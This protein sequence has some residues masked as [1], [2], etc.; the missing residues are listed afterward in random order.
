MNEIREVKKSDKKEVTVE[1]VQA[2]VND[3]AAKIRR[4]SSNW[5]RFAAVHLGS[6]EHV[7]GKLNGGFVPICILTAIAALS[8]IAG[9]VFAANWDISAPGTGTCKAED[10]AGTFTMT[11][12]V[13]NPTTLTISAGAL[14][15][16][17]VV[18]ADLAVAVQRLGVGSVA[19]VATPNA[20]G[21]TN[22]VV[23]TL[24][25]L[26]GNTLAVA[27]QASAFTF[28]I[29]DSAFGVPA[30]VAGNIV[31]SGGYEIKE[32]TDKAVYTVLTATN[33]TVTVTVTDT[34]GGTN[35]FHCVTG[36]GIVATPTT[37][38][39]NVP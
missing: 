37:M 27:G 32:L 29:S 15:D 9:S 24:A 25:D 10:A 36:G 7:D 1:S 2:R 34:P 19:A 26:G 39:F 6:D 11:V 31:V 12:D 28:F 20:N 5:K 13:M 30:A 4:L 21:G 8:L 16:N 3:M 17:S 22:V 18:A 33:G 23:C 35:Y 14:T 38:A